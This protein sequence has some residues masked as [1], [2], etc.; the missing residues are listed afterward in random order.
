MTTAYLIHKRAADLP[1]F[2][3]LP[4][5][6]GYAELVRPFNLTADQRPALVAAPPD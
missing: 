3:R 5:E 2:V 1:S 6:Q 4:D